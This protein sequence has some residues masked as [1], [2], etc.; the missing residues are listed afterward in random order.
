MTWY[1]ELQCL[2]NEI[3]VMQAQAS[4]ARRLT[5]HHFKHRH[6]GRTSRPA[7]QWLDEYRKT[8]RAATRARIAEIEAGAPQRV[9]REGYWVSIEEAGA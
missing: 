8:Y 7:R 1:T 2:K 6:D 3:N 9:W 5:L 4:N